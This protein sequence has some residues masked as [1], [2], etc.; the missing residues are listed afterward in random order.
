MPSKVKVWSKTSTGR[1]MKWPD[2]QFRHL[3]LSSAP[4]EK[5]M[6]GTEAHRATE[7][8]RPHNTQ[9]SESGDE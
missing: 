2:V 5:P 7:E 1:A 6:L 4:H 3:L 9:A 8:P